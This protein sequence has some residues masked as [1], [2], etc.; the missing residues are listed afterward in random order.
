MVMKDPTTRRSRV[1]APMGRRENASSEFCDGFREE[2]REERRKK[3]SGVGKDRLRE[4]GGGGG[5]DWGG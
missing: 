1:L 2:E 5:W 3:K 4:W